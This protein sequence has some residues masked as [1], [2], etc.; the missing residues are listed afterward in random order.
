MSVYML[1]S[2]GA[3]PIGSPFTGAVAD[4]IGIRA[5]VTV[6]GTL[7]IVGAAVGWLLSRRA[8]AVRVAGTGGAP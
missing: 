6:N 2:A 8:R 4:L 1:L 7:V 3:T 5:A